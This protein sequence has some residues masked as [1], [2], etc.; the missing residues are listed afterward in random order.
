MVFGARKTKGD[1]SIRVVSRIVVV[2]LQHVHAAT[3]RQ[4]LLLRLSVHSSCTTTTSRATATSLVASSSI[5]NATLLLWSINLPSLL[6][7]QHR[8]STAALSASST[9]PT[10]RGQTH[11]SSL[12]N[13][14]LSSHVG[15][16]PSLLQGLP[17]HNLDDLRPP[18]FLPPFLCTSD[19]HPVRPSTLE[20]RVVL[21]VV[22]RLASPQE[23]VVVVARD[24]WIERSRKRR[25]TNRSNSH[26][27]VHLFASSISYRFLVRR[28][29]SRTPTSSS[30]NLRLLLLLFL[31]LQPRDRLLIP[32]ERVFVA[33]NPR[34]PT[35][36]SSSHL[37]GL[38]HPCLR[39]S[40][41]TFLHQRLL[42]RIL[43]GSLLHLS[44][45]P[46]HSL[47]LRLLR[48]KGSS[49]HVRS[50]P[51]LERRIPL[52]SFVDQQLGNGEAGLT[53]YVG[54]DGWDWAREH[55]DR[56]GA[57]R[58]T[59]RREGRRGGGR[60]GRE[61]SSWHPRSRRARRE[62]WIGEVLGVGRIVDGFALR[63]RI[64]SGGG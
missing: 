55:G 14:H 28:R 3:G 9:P 64:G 52:G 24:W 23:A 46:S 38:V 61:S 57:R 50:P 29:K 39:P 31:L 22:V 18:P 41:R 56:R 15:H 37:R 20:L 51:S 40:S 63:K 6:L 35:L 4:P 5:S 27:V 53:R 45:Q 54:R 36:P 7:L 10:A 26:V 42:F 21:V 58:R 62:R 60:A 32:R 59:R 48:G 16:G 30:F 43:L 17:L 2:L 34:Q 25:R 8:I 47:R 13:K 44:P 33:I 11:L 19:H 49:S 12:P 1:V